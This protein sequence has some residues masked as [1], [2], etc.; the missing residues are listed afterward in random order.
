M[1][2]LDKRKFQNSVLSQ[3][4]SMLVTNRINVVC[5]EELERDAREVFG[6]TEEVMTQALADIKAWIHNTPY[7]MN[8]RQDDSFLRLFLRGCNHNVKETKEKL[9]MYFSVRFLFTIK[10]ARNIFI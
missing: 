5:A 3:S 7:M 8:V 10:D 4:A 9:D 2:I 1:T 6:E